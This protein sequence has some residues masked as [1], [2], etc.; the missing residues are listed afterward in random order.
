MIV[1]LSIGI[2]AIF[3]SCSTQPDD[4][5]TMPNL[6]GQLYTDVQNNEEYAF[7][8]SVETREDSSQETGCLLYTSRCV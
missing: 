6:V 8:F 5:M 1:A 7:K 2:A 4:T 3:R